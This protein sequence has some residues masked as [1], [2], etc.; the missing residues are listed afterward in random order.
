MKIIMT[1]VCLLLMGF[2]LCLAGDFTDNGDDT[3]TDH[4]TGLM[5]AKYTA[6]TDD[7]G[8]VD[9]NDQVN[10][11]DALDWCENLSLAGYDDWRLPTKKELRSIVD[12][13]TSEP[14]IDTTYFPNTMSWIYWTSTT[15]AYNRDNAWLVYFS[16]GYD[17]NN[18][19]SN[20]YYVRAVRGGQ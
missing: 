3:V 13:D 9:S 8:D 5:W 18:L 4:D 16:V 10:W 15:D 6:D 1:T 11:Q 2:S 19:K 20:T 14:A 17:G 7:D 12:Y